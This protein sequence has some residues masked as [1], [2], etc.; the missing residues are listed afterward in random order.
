MGTMA[1]KSFVY[2]GVLTGVNSAPVE[3]ATI[4]IP[5]H[6]S[7]TL[8]GPDGTFSIQLPIGCSDTVLISHVSYNELRVSADKLLTMAS[9]IIMQPKELD[10]LVV[11]DCKRKKARLAGKG[12]RIPGGVTTFTT[13]SLGNEIGTVVEVKRVFEVHE[14]SFTVCSNN[15]DNARVSMNIYKTDETGMT[16]MNKL[17]APVY[18]DIPASDGKQKITVVPDKPLVIEPGIYFVSLMFVD[19][20]S[21]A[22]IDNGTI[23]FPLYIK[24]SYTRKG[25]GCGLEKV[26]VNMGLDVSGFEYR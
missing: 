2:K 19:C 4:S 1:Q 26:P 8:S 18:A 10:E 21:S 5:S 15:I 7:G 16:F 6:R 11:Y 23:H 14:F 17:H 24:R 22:D 3:Y 9:P 12:T 25:A 20:G 13:G